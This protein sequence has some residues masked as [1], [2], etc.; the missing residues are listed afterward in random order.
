MMFEYKE[1]VERL[2]YRLTGEVPEGDVI[3]RFIS[4]GRGEE[5]L[6]GAVVAEHGKSIEYVT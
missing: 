4:D 3:E 1:T 2:Y 5:L 6:Q